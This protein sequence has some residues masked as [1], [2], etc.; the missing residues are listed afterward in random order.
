MLAIIIGTFSVMPLTQANA[1]YNTGSIV[2]SRAI[3]IISNPGLFKNCNVKFI[4][5]RNRY[6]QVTSAASTTNPQCRVYVRQGWLDLNGAYR[7]HST[8]YAPSTFSITTSAKKGSNGTFCVGVA[9]GPYAKYGTGWACETI[10][11]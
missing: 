5:T 9:A 10:R 3:N 1:G 7:G 6:G 2:G 11:F 8:G 4:N